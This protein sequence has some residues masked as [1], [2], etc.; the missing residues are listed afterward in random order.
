MPLCGVLCLAG[1]CSTA[2]TRLL[3]LLQLVQGKPGRLR[4][5]RE[6]SVAIQGEIEAKAAVRQRIQGADQ[7]ATRVC[8]PDVEGIQ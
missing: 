2:L 5:V 4:I 3:S 8:Q 7:L 6:D 1:R